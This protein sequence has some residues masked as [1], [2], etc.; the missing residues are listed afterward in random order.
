MR[1]G[2]ERVAADVTSREQ[3]AR[4]LAGADVVIHM[5]ALLHINNPPP[6]MADRYRQV[7]VLG[8]ENVV[9]GTPPGARLVYLSTI[10]VYGYAGRAG[11]ELTEQTVPRPDSTYGETKLAA[12]RAVLNASGAVLRLAAVYGPRVKGNYRRLVKAIDRHRFVSIGS[13]SNR[14]TLV[15][16]RDVA[17]AVLIAARHDAARGDVFNVTDGSVHTVNEIVSA[18]SSALETPVP[19]LRV[20]VAPVRMALAASDR[21]F[22]LIRLRPPLSAALIDKYMEEVVVSGRKANEVLG[23]TPD[24]DLG[25]GWSETVAAMRLDGSI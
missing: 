10:A 6:E 5:A 23:F 7:N 14:R 20:P 21:I 17:E 18:I 2:V 4:A 25:R 16:D 13:G 22:G 1:S 19:R 12:E 15:Y 9:A 24:Y 8:T 11:Q 3:V